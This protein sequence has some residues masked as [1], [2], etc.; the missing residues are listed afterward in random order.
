MGARRSRFNSPASPAPTQSGHLHRLGSWFVL[1][2]LGLS[3]RKCEPQP[4]L[5]QLPVD[6]RKVPEGD[7]A[8][9]AG[10]GET[11]FLGVPRQPIDGAFAVGQCVAQLTRGEI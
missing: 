2:W 7:V 8:V 9:V 4:Q 1:G 6:L 11:R 5:R 3:R 10:D